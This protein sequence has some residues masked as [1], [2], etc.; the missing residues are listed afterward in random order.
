MLDGCNGTGA[1]KGSWLSYPASAAN[2]RRRSSAERASGP[3][4]ASSP[5]GWFITGKWPLAEMRPGVGFSP[6]MPQKPLHR[7]HRSGSEPGP[8]PQGGEHRRHVLVSGRVR[9]IGHDQVVYGLT[10]R[11]TATVLTTTGATGEHP[12]HPAGDD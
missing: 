2:S 1:E 10:G 6:A 5:P 4:T 9:G 3:A 12:F 8:V 11:L 7:D